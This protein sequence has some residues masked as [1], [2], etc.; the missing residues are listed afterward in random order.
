[1][2]KG[3]CPECKVRN[4]DDSEKDL[5]KCPFC[6]REFCSDHLD[7]K[8]AFFSARFNISKI[9]DP[10]YREELMRELNKENAHPCVPYTEKRLKELDE[11]RRMR[12][13]KISKAL[14]R[15][16]FAR[17]VEYTEKERPK[18]YK[19]K[20]YKQK[21]RSRSKKL[22]I[23]S[24]SILLLTAFYLLFVSP[25]SIEKIIK[26]LDFVPPSITIIS[27]EN[28][29][30]TTGEI[31]LIFKVDEP[32]SH[33][34][35]NLNGMGNVL[36][37]GNTTLKNISPGRYNLTIYANDTAGNTGYSKISFTVTK[38]F[39]SI[40]E[41]ISY[42]RID[43]LSD[44][45]W[46]ANYTCVEFAEDFIK[47]AEAKGYYCFTQYDLFDDEL[48]EFNKAIESIE[49]TK[50]YSWGTE[51][52]WYDAFYISG[53]GHAVV[54][55]TINGMDF[56]VDPQTDVILSYP[57]FTVLYEGEITQD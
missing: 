23:V 20:I 17:E 18:L 36:L 55:T 9:K 13:E 29:T 31:K 57:D 10:Q 4:G 49:V 33:A 47:R 22:A 37:S 21:K 35:Y 5:F 40:E 53:V 42:L 12:S 46:T 39:S 27:P 48:I 7:P 56:I 45:E 32:I 44:I 28:K 52:R 1:M 26:V 16:K 54:R 38:V 41:L 34:Y 25:S 11:E 50:T 51:T 3:T 43:N 30:Y 15:L 6:G 8:L 24:I 2:V 19:S 14:D